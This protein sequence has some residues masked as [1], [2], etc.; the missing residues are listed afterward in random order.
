[1]SFFSEQSF[2][3]DEIKRRYHPEMI[4]DLKEVIC[5]THWKTV[6]GAIYFIK[7]P[8]TDIDFAV[9][10]QSLHSVLG[11]QNL[12]PF[13]KKLIKPTDVWPVKKWACQN[14]HIARRHSE[15]ADFMTESL[16]MNGANTC[17]HLSR[18]DQRKEYNQKI[19]MGKSNGKM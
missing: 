13:L 9:D 7:D 14:A 1:M 8:D 17:P 18:E 6:L 3:N 4:K 12:V 19:A 16:S 11:K 15:K 2:S 5:I 10:H